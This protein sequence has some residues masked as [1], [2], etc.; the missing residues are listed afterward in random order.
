MI[1]PKKIKVLSRDYVVQ[2]MSDKKIGEG[3]YSGTCNSDTAI[4]T[5]SAEYPSQKQAC[6]LIH[7]LL[8]AVVNEMGMTN[9]PNL[10]KFEISEETIV[11]T[12]AN[13]L[14][15]VIRDN[16]LLIPAIQKGLN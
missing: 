6:T 15:A 11:N 4:I 14:A 8:H 13:G 2:E 5:I 10:E 1:L 3:I 9:V 7:E 16:P 12:L